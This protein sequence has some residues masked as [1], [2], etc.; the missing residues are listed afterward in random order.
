MVNSST[1]NK[2]MKQNETSNSGRHQCVTQLSADPV[3]QSV[4]LVP[5]MT[6]LFD[7]KVEIAFHEPVASNI[8]RTAL[9]NQYVIAKLLESKYTQYY[10]YKEHEEFMCSRRA[11]AQTLQGRTSY[12]ASYRFWA[13]T[14]QH[15]HE[16]QTPSGVGTIYR[17][18]TQAT[19]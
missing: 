2:Q 16:A 17:I 11:G 12:Y 19:H 14:T 7:M 13:M 3:Q 6:E 15:R 5:R 10:C 18:S 1:F 8:Q 9:C 4:R